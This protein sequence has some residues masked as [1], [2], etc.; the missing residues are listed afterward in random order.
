[1]NR[2]KGKFGKAMKPVSKSCGVELYLD[3]PFS[4]EHYD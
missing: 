3:S 2:V 4:L 1:M